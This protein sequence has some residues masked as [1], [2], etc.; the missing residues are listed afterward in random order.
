MTTHKQ[1]GFSMIEVLVAIS[2]VAL[3]LAGG[4]AVSMSLAQ[5]S[6]RAPQTLLAELCARN[7]LTALRLSRQWPALGSSQQ[8]CEQ[9]GQSL[10]VVLTVSSTGNPAFRQVQAQ[11]SQGR[12]PVLRVATVVGQY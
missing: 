10:S 11:V 7:T 5:H 12:E 2:I 6:A 1:A 3:A 4:L 8:M 9:A